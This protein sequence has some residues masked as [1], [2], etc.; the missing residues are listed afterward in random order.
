[1]FILESQSDE[2][3]HSI[4][5]VSVSQ[6]SSSLARPPSLSGRFLDPD[7]CFEESPR[8]DLT[9]GTLSRC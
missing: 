9:T 4:H 5:T 6:V 7:P 3:W 2:L 8:P 1:M